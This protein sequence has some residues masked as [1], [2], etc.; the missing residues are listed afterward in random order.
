[1]VGHLWNNSASL[2]LAE[3][4]GHEYIDETY[5]TLRDAL[6]FFARIQEEDQKRTLKVSEWK[7]FGA[8]LL[9][10]HLAWCEKEKK[11]K[12]LEDMDAALG[13]VQKHPAIIVEVLTEA[14]KSVSVKTEEAGEDNA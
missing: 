3:A 14:V 13:Y 1:M 9:A 10:S 12:E 4:L 5:N 11:A 2:H 7:A 8:I 6:N